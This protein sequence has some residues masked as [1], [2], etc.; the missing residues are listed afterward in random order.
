[1]LE[2]PLLNISS[3]YIRETIQAGKSI[4]YMVPEAVRQ[5]IELKGYY[6]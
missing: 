6:R 3:T 4:R 2:V 5:E 1:M